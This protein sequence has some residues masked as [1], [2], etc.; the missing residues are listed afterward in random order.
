MV[1]AVTGLT[2]GDAPDLWR[3]LGFTLADDGTCTVGDVRI[4]FTADGRGLRAW[5][6]HGVHVDGDRL[7]GLRTDIEAA[8]P[9]G[10][11]H[12]NGITE[13][14]HVV[15]WTPDHD[16]TIDALADAG[17]E[18]RRTTGILEAYGNKV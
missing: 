5:S 6:V 11:P 12:P 17:F 14:N 8:P 13:I 18:L 4:R 9:R 2:V 7:D 16:R 10:E 3:E 15:V 1:A